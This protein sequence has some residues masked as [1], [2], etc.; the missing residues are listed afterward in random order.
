MGGFPGELRAF[1][2]AAEI[3]G[4][5]TGPADPQRG[6]AAG[7]KKMKNV[8]PPAEVKSIIPVPNAKPPVPAAKKVLAMGAEL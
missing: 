1:R 5:K 6:A 3:H 4:K 8:Q 7:I 2:A